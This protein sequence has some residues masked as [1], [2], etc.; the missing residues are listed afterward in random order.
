M[1]DGR[2]VRGHD[3]GDEVLDFEIVDL[4]ARKPLPRQRALATLSLALQTL[5]MFVT[6]RWYRQ[7]AVQQVW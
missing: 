2:N 3:G 5:T 4:S 6:S 1:F 7:I